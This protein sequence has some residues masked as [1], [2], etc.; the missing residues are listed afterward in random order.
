MGYDFTDIIKKAIQTHK[1]RSKTYNKNYYKFG[2]IMHAMFP[3]GLTIKG[4]DMWSAF[5]L[6]FM[7]MVKISRNAESFAINKKFD[8][9]TTHDT[10]VYSFI[11]EEVIAN[12]YGGAD[13][14]DC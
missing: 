2:E 10:G 3:L 4:A 6:F 12:L 5:G 1:K 14:N 11:L 8:I 7:M 9:D 13:D